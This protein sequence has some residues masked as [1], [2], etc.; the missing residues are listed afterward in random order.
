[1]CL[2][3]RRKITF[4]EYFTASSFLQYSN[5]L[6]VVRTENT[7]IKNAVTNSG[8][9]LLIKNGNDYN[10]SYLASG[11]YTGISG[12]EF[13]VEMQVHMEM[14]YLFL[15]VH[16]RQHMKLKV[17]QQVN[18]SAVSAGD[19]QITV[20]SGTN[21]GVGDVIAFSTTAEQ[22]TMMMVRSMK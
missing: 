14:V 5:A 19:T 8:T 11:A 13:V 10:T 21:I 17:L 4:E 12:I 9:A 7:G 16:Q 3:N 15:Y 18:D 22:M 1:M 20:T 6:K 2:V